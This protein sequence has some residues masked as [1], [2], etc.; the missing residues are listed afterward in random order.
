MAASIG[1]LTLT[2]RRPDLLRRRALASV[3]AQDHPGEIVHV[4]IVDDDP[5]TV[6]VVRAAPTRPGLRVVPFPVPRP[7]AEADERPGDRRGSYPRLSRLLNLA[8]RA[9]RT[10]WLAVLDDDNEYEPDHLS[11]LLACAEAHSAPA[12][13]S[14]RQLFT[15]DGEP[16]TAPLWHT[17]A[18]PAEAARIHRLMCERGV[19]V[20]GT[21]VLLDR[22]DP[23]RSVTLRPSSVIR[24]E[25]PVQLVDQNVWLVRRGL[26]LACPWPETFSEEDHASNAAPDDKFLL[27]LLVRG[28]RLVST[29]RPTVRYYLGG[30]SNGYRPRPAAQPAQA[31]G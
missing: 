28:V 12:V 16:Y 29:G 7:P 2:R 25:D 8:A 11:S 17:V 23:V 21:N 4:V 20:P 1:V 24:P 14:G 15:A 31:T 26:M 22:A 27:A 13:H 10:D 19:R 5:A 30:M 18:D 3:Y 6:P 9:C